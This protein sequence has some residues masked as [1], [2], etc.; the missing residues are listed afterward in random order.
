MM[1]ADV[2]HKEAVV[3]IG[4]REVKGIDP[5]P[6]HDPIREPSGGRNC[7]QYEVKFTTV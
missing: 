3:A 7:P 2:F 4:Q 5:G 1:W 6:C